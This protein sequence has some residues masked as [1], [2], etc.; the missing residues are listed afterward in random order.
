MENENKRSF[1]NRE[2]LPPF[3][4]WL[5]VERTE[6]ENAEYALLILKKHFAL[7]GLKLRESDPPF[8]WNSFGWTLYLNIHEFVSNRERQ[9]MLTNLLAELTDFC[10]AAT[11]EF[12]AYTLKVLFEK[13]I[14]RDPPRSKFVSLLPEKAVAQFVQIEQMLDDDHE[15]YLEI[16]NQQGY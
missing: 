16:L 6:K 1:E 14:D 2:D 10:E 15:R 11:G 7:D 3:D 8:S 4:E 12:F 13:F 5:K 9:P